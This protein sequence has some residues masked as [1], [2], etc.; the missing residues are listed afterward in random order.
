LL[1]LGSGRS[2]G[3]LPRF[4]NIGLDWVTSEMVRVTAGRNPGTGSGWECNLSAEKL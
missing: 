3:G 2:S 1:G 4:S